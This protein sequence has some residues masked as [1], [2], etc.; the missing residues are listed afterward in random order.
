[1]SDSDTPFGQATRGGSFEGSRDLAKL[2]KVFA[3]SRGGGV[4]P[5]PLKAKANLF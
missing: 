3:T 2:P 4:Y 1:M 5:Y